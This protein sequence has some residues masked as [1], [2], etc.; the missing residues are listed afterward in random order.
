M[1]CVFHNTGHRKEKISALM[2]AAAGGN[3]E[4]TKVLL[5]HHANINLK[6]P[7]I[8]HTNG[9]KMVFPGGYTALTMASYY[10]KAEILKLLLKK[11]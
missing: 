11:G 7:P 6:S 2:A 5:Q 8:Q 1:S 10:G 9:S 3:L 4:C